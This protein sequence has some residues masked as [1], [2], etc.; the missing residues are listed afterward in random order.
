MK[1]STTKK[2]TT[3]IPKMM[4]T[5][6]ENA[7]LDRLRTQRSHDQATRTKLTVREVFASV[8]KMLDDAKAGLDRKAYLDLCVQVTDAAQLRSDNVNDELAREWHGVDGE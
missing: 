7:E 2:R 4:T 5:T 6:S 8:N 3:T 1:I